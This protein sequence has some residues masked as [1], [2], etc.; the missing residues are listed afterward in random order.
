M[1][2]LKARSNHQRGEPCYGPVA[3]VTTGGVTSPDVDLVS[4]AAI[5]S[6]AAI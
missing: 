4:L 5:G 1:P 6:V 3:E 2:S